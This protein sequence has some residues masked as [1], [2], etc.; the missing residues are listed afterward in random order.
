MHWISTSLPS[1]SH[2]LA[3]ALKFLPRPGIKEMQ[4]AE[5]ISIAW[6]WFQDTKQ[7]LVRFKNIYIKNRFKKRYQARKDL[8]KCHSS[9]SATADG[10]LLKNNRNA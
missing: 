10:F 9:T 5:R 4:L 6:S 1:L 3:V 8:E 2:I 7:E